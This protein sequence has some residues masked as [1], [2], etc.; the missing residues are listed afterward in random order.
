MR[1]KHS[2]NTLVFDSSVPF[3]TT[4]FPDPVDAEPLKKMQFVIQVVSSNCFDEGVKY[5]APPL[6]AEQDEKRM[7]WR[8]TVDDVE[9]YNP[10]PLDPA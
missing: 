6:T 1:V 5:I 7:F 9:L 3:K 10:P 2:S 8:V 4:S